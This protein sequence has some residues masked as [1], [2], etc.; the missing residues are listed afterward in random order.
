MTPANKFNSKAAFDPFAQPIT[1]EPNAP[2]NRPS[3]LEKFQT[4]LSELKT[5]L[6][7]AQAA[8]IASDA[9]ENLN[10]VFHQTNSG[11]RQAKTTIEKL[12]SAAGHFNSNNLEKELGD[13]L[14]ESINTAGGLTEGDQKD[15]FRIEAYKLMNAKIVESIKKIKGL[16]KSDGVI[17]FKV[18]VT[19]KSQKIRLIIKKKESNSNLVRDEINQA[20]C[21]LRPEFKRPMLEIVPVVNLAYAGDVPEFGVTN[22]SITQNNKDNFTFKAGA[23]LL[24]NVLNFG[25]YKDGAWGVGLGYNI[26][27]SDILESF[28]LGTLFSYKNIFRLGGGVGYSEFASGLKDGA[29]VGSPLPAD[30][31]NINDIVTY[32]KRPAFFIT[33]SISGITVLSKK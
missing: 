26:P 4:T 11:F 16:A 29:K 2:P 3:Y 6:Q 22:N 33:F 13:M 1:R 12:S 27:K 7:A 10:D 8:I 15:E 24:F 21:T 31:A 9:P 32:E 18:E 20:I 19:D 28:Y 14:N 23:M 30:I 17:R 25:K 5:E